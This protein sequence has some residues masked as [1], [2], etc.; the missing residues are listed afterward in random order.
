MKAIRV[1]YEIGVPSH[2]VHDKSRVQFY[3][4]TTLPESSLDL[5]HVSGNRFPVWCEV[6]LIG[7]ESIRFQRIGCAIQ[8]FVVEKRI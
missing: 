4:D 3:L 8:K 6:M 5:S 1:I 7:N 2:I